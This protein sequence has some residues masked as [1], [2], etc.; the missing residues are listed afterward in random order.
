MLEALRHGA[1]VI[2]RRARRVAAERARLLEAL[3]ERPSRSRPAQANFALDRGRPRWTAPSWPRASAR[4]RVLV[5]AGGPL[6]DARHVR[7]AIQDKLAT[8]RLLRAL[9]QRA[10]LSRAG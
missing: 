8:D 5:R 6:G 7:V 9:E 3:R 4:Q 2:E 10:R 1:R